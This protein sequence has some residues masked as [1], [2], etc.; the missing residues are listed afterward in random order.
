MDSPAVW[1]FIWLAVAATFGVGEIL[2]AGT[3][4]LLP[5]AA[6]ALAPAF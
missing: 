4:F 3:F 6:G 5:F 2:V 1:A